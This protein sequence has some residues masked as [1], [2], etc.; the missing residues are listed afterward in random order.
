M[1]SVRASTVRSIRGAGAAWMKCTWRDG[2]NPS[3]STQRVYVKDMTT[4]EV[5]EVSAPNA[6]TNTIRD[7]YT[8]FVATLRRVR[9]G[10]PRVVPRG[11]RPA[12]DRR[13]P[14]GLRDRVIAAGS[15]L[16]TREFG[17]TYSDNLY[18]LSVGTNGSAL[19]SGYTLGDLG[20]S[21]EPVGALLRK[22]DSDGDELWMPR[23]P[24]ARSS[25]AAS[26]TSPR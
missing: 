9:V 23:A 22:Y 13:Y 12:R 2:A 15:V 14:A 26:Y 16:W 17:T 11:P 5:V 19:V 24:T 18:S 4:G 10:A 1:T 20:G 21:G 3:Y 25:Q 8:P 7:S 6:Y